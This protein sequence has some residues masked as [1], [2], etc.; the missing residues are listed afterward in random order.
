MK[1]AVAFLVVLFP[2][3][4]AFG[5]GFCADDTSYWPK[6]ATG[7]G[8]AIEIRANTWLSCNRPDGS[9]TPSTEAA[10]CW[11]DGG[12]LSGLV[13]QQSAPT[14]TSSS[15]VEAADART[16]CRLAL[17]V[18]PGAPAGT[19][20]LPREVWAAEADRRGL[21]PTYCQRLVTGTASPSVAVAAATPAAPSPP[22]VSPLVASIQALL[23]ALGFDP[24][25]TDGAP[26]PQTAKAIAAYQA[27]IGTPPDGQPSEALRA[28]LQRAVAE[29]GGGTRPAPPDPRQKGVTPVGTGSGF[30]LEK[31]IVVTNNHVIDGCTE[32]RL[33]RNGIDMGRA[34]LIATNRSDDLAALR[35]EQPWDTFLE[36]RAEP[37]LKAAE[38]VVVFG[39]PLSGA[40]SSAGNTTLGN[41]TALA[42]LRDDSRHIQISAAVQPGN[43]GGPVLDE[44]GRLI[45]VVDS[46]IDD[47]A[48]AKRTGAIPQNINFAIRA[49]TLANFLD[50]NGISYSSAVS[51]EALGP[52]RVAER[53]AAAS[54]QIIC[55]K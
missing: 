36:L 23:A 20:P 18:G 54:A 53:A 16:V 46:R 21:A 49:S 14:T 6:P 34:P 38:G 47:M 35:T 9:T 33:R 7:C 31:N 41:V 55:L 28:R 4:H 3:S 26:G 40:L 15:T 50:A 48:I 29:R 24:G 44:A 1:S 43:S 37:R 22:A 12:H 30:F 5:Q 11:R 25:P 52:T 39:Y 2:I 17:G 8:G 10:I 42:G 27:S 19:P 13:P 45:G 32:I 51:G